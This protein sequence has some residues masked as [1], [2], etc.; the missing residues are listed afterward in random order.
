MSLVR[1]IARPM[2]AS[3]FI[4]GGVN[5][6]KNADFLAGR[7]QPV[8]EKLAPVIDRATSA[9]LSLD[10]KQLVQLNAAVHLVGG[11]MLATGRA[12][13]YLQSSGQLGSRRSS[14]S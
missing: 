2:L 12:L 10:S 9:S 14:T 6:L 8:T 13:G 11:L 4:S 1:R 5:S 3:M 7:A